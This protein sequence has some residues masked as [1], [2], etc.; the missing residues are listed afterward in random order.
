MAEDYFLGFWAQET[1]GDEWHH[2]HVCGKLYFIDGMRRQK[3]DVKAIY[4]E[5]FAISTVTMDAQ[6]ITSYKPRAPLS[7]ITNGC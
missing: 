3:F 6:I 1:D 4:E 2:Y 7:E 5:S